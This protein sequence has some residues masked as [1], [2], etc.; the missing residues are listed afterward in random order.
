M[1]ASEH[2][3][4]VLVSLLSVMQFCT[5]IA[6][7]VTGCSLKTPQCFLK[8]A[9]GDT[10]YFFFTSPAAQMPGCRFAAPPGHLLQGPGCS[11][12]V[13]SNEIK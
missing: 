6:F 12:D 5:V 4:L 8:Q 7:Q 2:L 13:I 1:V 9:G 11:I 3:A 10:C